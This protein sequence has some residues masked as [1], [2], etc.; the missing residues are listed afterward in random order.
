ME[1]ISMDSLLR[2]RDLIKRA[3]VNLFSMVLYYCGFFHLTRFFSNKIGPG[4]IILCF[5]RV[6]EKEVDFYSSPGSQVLLE[7]FKEQIK[8]FTRIFHFI[9]LSE[10]VENLKNDRMPAN[11]MVLTFDDGFRDSY[12]HVFPLLKEQGLPAVFFISPKMLGSRNLLWQNEPWYL[13]NAHQHQKRF[14][15]KGREWDLSSRQ[16]KAEAHYFMKKT[17]FQS[18]SD[19]REGLLEDIRKRFH[20]PDPPESS[21]A[22]LMLSK[23]DIARMT[24]TRLIEFGA[25]SMNHPLLSQCSRE[26]LDD[27]IRQSKSELEFATKQDI[28]F[29]AY[30]FGEYSPESIASLKKNHYVAAVTTK[31]GIV[32]REDNVF[33]LNR[34]NVVRDDTAYSILIRKVAPQYLKRILTR[35]FGSFNAYP[36]NR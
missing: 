23:E 13:L 25:H 31:E 35:Y 18:D 4:T 21:N 24:A 30:P 16:G 33:T 9:R 36:K 14:Q 26:E 32:R 22:A 1:G 10:L 12:T 8:Q 27:E 17:L 5:H 34:I 6:V 7:K 20:S 29:F 15:W 19:E 11:Q 28:L 2:L 3:I